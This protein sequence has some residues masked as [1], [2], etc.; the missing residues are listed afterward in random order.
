MRWMR[1]RVI[2]RAGKVLF[3]NFSESKCEEFAKTCTE[4]TRIV[5]HWYSL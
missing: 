4:E 2:N 5:P 3:S 1:Y